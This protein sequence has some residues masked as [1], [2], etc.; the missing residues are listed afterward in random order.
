M[1]KLEEKLEQAKSFAIALIQQI[2]KRTLNN[3]EVH[4]YRKDEDLG[5]LQEFINKN[6][7]EIWGIKIKFKECEEQ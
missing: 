4:I 3:Q 2:P 5:T 6:L 7:E 1:T